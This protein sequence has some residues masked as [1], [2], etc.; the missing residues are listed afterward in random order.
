MLFEMCNALMKLRFSYHNFIQCKSSES[1]LKKL[2]I[3]DKAEQIFSC[4]ESGIN[5]HVATREKVY[6]IF[7]KR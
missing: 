7:K 2:D 3:L 4:D 5:S 1:Q 6:G